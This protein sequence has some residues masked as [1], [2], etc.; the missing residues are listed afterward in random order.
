MDD[1]VLDEVRALAARGIR[2]VEFLG[3]TVN[4]YRDP[5]GNTLGELLVATA[6]VDGIER[7]RF[8]TSHPAQ[9]TNG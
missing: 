5:A 7:I 6:R 4:A 3:Q 1:D 2:E 8:T 9:M